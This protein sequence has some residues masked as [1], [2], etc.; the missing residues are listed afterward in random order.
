MRLVLDLTAAEEQVLRRA[1][2]RN[3]ET[4]EETLLRLAGLVPRRAALSAAPPDVIYIIKDVRLATSCGLKEAK[5]AVEACAYDREAAIE[6]LRT[7]G[8]VRSCVARPWTA[9]DVEA[10][11]RH[12]GISTE[13]G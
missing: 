3:G 8:V 7:V 9:D 5:E 6:L 2:L 11:L 12:H 1:Q 4:P 10:V 13:R